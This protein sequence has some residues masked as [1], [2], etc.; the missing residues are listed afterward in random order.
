MAC[1]G[2][3]HY[4]CNAHIASWGTM[5]PKNPIQSLQEQEVTFLKASGNRPVPQTYI[6]SSPKKVSTFNPVNFGH[7]CVRDFTMANK[8]IFCRIADPLRG[9]SSVDNI[10]RPCRDAETYLKISTLQ[11]SASALEPRSL[12]H[13]IFCPRKGKQ[14][15]F[16]T[17]YSIFK[18]WFIII[19]SWSHS[20]G[21]F[22]SHFHNLHID[23]EYQL[24]Q[25]SLGIK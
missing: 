1:I 11:D 2:C 5:Q 21:G 25:H 8:N 10:C 19:S 17:A 9:A 24:P 20:G 14:G 23:L 15:L 18:S 6:C 7:Y 3:V 16:F 13:L 4:Y 22:C 12:W